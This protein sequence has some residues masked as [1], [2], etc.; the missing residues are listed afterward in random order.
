MLAHTFVAWHTTLSTP[1]S[2]LAHCHSALNIIGT[3]IHHL[4]TCHRRSRLPLPTPTP[5]PIPLA[6][7]SPSDGHR[8]PVG[9][10]RKEGGG[11]QGERLGWRSSTCIRSY[12]IAHADVGDNGSSPICPICIPSTVVTDCKAT[13][14]I[15]YLNHMVHMNHL[16]G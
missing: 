15:V 12:L 2:M 8:A 10:M 5:T 4:R 7:P 9:S 14:Y 11:R 6:S 16:I 1:S 13:E 3:H